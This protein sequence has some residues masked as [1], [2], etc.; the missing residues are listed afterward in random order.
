VGINRKLALW[1]LLITV[2]VLAIFIDVFPFI[3][4]TKRLNRLSS[5]LEKLEKYTE[6]NNKL[7]QKENYYLNIIG[8]DKKLA[9]LEKFLVNN[10]INYSKKDNVI[11]FVGSMYSTKFKSFVELVQ[12]SSD[13]VFLE[14]KCD[15]TR[16]LPI[17]FGES[18][19]TL[20]VSG[21]IK[22]MS[23]GRR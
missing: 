21:K 4:S 22:Y 7:T 20:N 17:A 23:M 14:F 8:T 10:N 13:L 15:N 12:N 3:N 19:D 9:E 1:G 16:E 18:V 5:E 11:E 2:I 6:I